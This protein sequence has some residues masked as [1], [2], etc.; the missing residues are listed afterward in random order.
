MTSA[1]ATLAAGGVRHTPSLERITRPDGTALAS[2]APPGVRALPA[3]VAAEVTSALEGVVRS[4]TGR[5]ADI[6]GP[7]AGKTGTAE[8]FVDAWFCGYVPHLATCVWIG[9]PRAE[10]PMHDV[11][12]FAQVVGGS[13]PRESGT[14]SWPRRHQPARSSRPRAAPAATSGLGRLAHAVRNRAPIAERRRPSRRAPRRSSGL[15]GPST[16]HVHPA[17][18]GSRRA[19]APPSRRPT[20]STRKAR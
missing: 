12:G 17:P 8:N 7:V 4:G 13:V 15:L 2:P 5:A 11:D 20:P 6:G 3:P 14:T 19:R 18:D 10:T 1:F 16:R 9:N